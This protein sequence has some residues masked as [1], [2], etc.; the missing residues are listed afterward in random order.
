MCVKRR[1]IGGITAYPIHNK[2]KT[3]GMLSVW[4]S[5]LKVFP[6]IFHKE[7]LHRIAGYERSLSKKHFQNKNYLKGISLFVIAIIK[8]PNWLIKK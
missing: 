5:V 1:N 6:P 3:K 4:R 8:N 2:N 7:I